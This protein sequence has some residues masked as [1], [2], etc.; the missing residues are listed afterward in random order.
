V[1]CP[2]CPHTGTFYTLKQLGFYR[3]TGDSSADL[4]VQILGKLKR[5]GLVVSG[6]IGCYTLSV[7][8]PLQA[9]DTCG[10]M[11]ASIGGALGMEKAGLANRVVAV[12]GDSTFLHSGMTAL[13]DVVYNGGT[14]TTIIL[15]NSTTAMTGHQ[16]NP[17]TGRAVSGAETRRVDLERL[18]RGLGVDDVKVVGA[19]DLA[20]VAAAIQDSVERPE[21]SVVIVKGNCALKARA[22]GEA[23]QVDQESCDG[24]GACLRTGCPAISL[25][26]G[27]ARIQPG[28]CVG[29]ACGVCAQ[30]CPFDAIWGK[31]DGEDPIPHPPVLE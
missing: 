28:T 2:G 10:C 1:L 31:G 15:D 4:P 14:V 24:C 16:D 29:A 26:D 7:L 27:I 23:F 25:R 19:F 13:L 30:V 18:V 6:D 8:P 11:G 17:G 3:P 9:M 21:P 22:A 5:S 12:I 20:A